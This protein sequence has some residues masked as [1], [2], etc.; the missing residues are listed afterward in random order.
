MHTYE[1]NGNFYEIVSDDDC[2]VYD[3]I[4]EYFTE[5]FNKLII[6]LVIL[7]VTKFG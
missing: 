1:L 6:Y 3:D 2:F 7:L 4:K 5:Y